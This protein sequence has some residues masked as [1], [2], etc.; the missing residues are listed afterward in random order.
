M[1]M[2]IRCSVRMLVADFAIL[3]DDGVDPVLGGD[4]GE[5]LRLRAVP[6][7]RE[8]MRDEAG[9]LEPLVH[10]AQVVLRAAQPVDEEYAVGRVDLLRRG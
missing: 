2:P 9:V 8:R 6:G 3:G 10:R 4:A 7:Q 1:H 5:I